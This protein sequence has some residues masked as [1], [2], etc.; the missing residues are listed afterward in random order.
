MGRFPVVCSNN[1]I[2]YC[3]QVSFMVQMTSVVP[4]SVTDGAYGSEG[5]NAEAE[6][7]LADP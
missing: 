7:V 5:D 6:L 4:T 3:S 2:S 1:R